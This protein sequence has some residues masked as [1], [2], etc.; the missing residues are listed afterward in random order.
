[1]K[2]YLSDAFKFNDA[3]NKQMLQKIKLLPDKEPGIKYLSHLINSQNKW[4]ERILRNPEAQQMDWWNPVYLL[5]ELEVK[6]NSSVQRWL[7]YIASKTE[8][9]LYTEVM[10]TGYDDAKWTATPVGS[11]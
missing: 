3:A 5:D 10:F 8:E 6:W 2:Q 11:V 1:M 7:D 4:L 9:E